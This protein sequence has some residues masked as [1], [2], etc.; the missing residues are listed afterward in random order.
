M[1][2]LLVLLSPGDNSLRA[3]EHPVPESPLW[4]RTP[5]ETAGRETHRPDAADQEYRSEYALPMLARMLAKHHGF[6][7][8]VLF[9]LN[10]KR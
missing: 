3:A 2:A 1:F 10:D 6:H 8:T 4:L 5:A 7:C 9:S